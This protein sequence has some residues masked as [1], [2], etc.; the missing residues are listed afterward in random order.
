TPS[1]LFPASQ[2]RVSRSRSRRLQLTLV[3][4][5]LVE[6]VRSRNV[7]VVQARNL[8]PVSRSPCRRLSCTPG[9]RLTLRCPRK[10]CRSLISRRARFARI[11]LLKTLV[12]FLMATP[13]LLWLF[14]AALREKDKMHRQLH[15]GVTKEG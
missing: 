15:G 6:V 14:T 7:H 9:T 5:C 13:S 10:C 11:F 12:T 2:Q 1:A 8:P 3:E 4:I